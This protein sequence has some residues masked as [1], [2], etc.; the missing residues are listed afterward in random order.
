M[1][2][3]LDKQSMTWKS[4]TTADRD[5]LVN[6]ITEVDG[7]DLPAVR[8][9][10]GQLEEI[11]TSA[12]KQIADLTIGAFDTDG[13]LVAYGAV[14]P[15]VDDHDAVFDVFVSGAV[16]PSLRGLGLGRQALGWAVTKA[17][18]LIRDNGDRG[19]VLAFLDDSSSTQWELYEWAGFKPARFF[20]TLRRSLATPVSE[21]S[22]DSRFTLV[23]W[24]PELVDEVKK[25]YLESFA[26]NISDGDELQANW[27]H[28][29]EV[30]HEP[31]SFV[32][33]AKG[34][35]SRGQSVAG[36]LIS[37]RYEDDWALRG[38]SFGFIEAVGVSRDYRGQ[39][40]ALALISH[41]LVAYQREGIDSA[42]L[43][44]DSESRDGISSRYASSILEKVGGGRLFELEV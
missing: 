21:I 17:K 16:L 41:T 15:V 31:W 20:S 35:T 22:L 6:L 14:E 23:P 8:M 44:I 24:A 39:K 36:F 28:L 4:L 18:E 33:F 10:S 29:L 32:V 7:L 38:Y 19:R 26:S 12:E 2:A 25:T 42:E 3:E 11:L 1:V 30:I 43:D 34:P 37:A 9:V 5:A 40:I 27:D 13:S